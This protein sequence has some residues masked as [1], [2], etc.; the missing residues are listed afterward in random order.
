MS[1]HLFIGPMFSGKTGELLRKTT[2][3]ADTG[4]K[5]ILVIHSRDKRE[6]TYHDGTVTT[7]SSQFRNLSPKVIPMFAAT[8][9]EID[10]QLPPDV[11]VIG[12]DELQ[13]FPDI[14]TYCP[15]WASRGIE[16]IGAGL[17]GDRNRRPF[18]DVLH[19][20]PYADKCIK[21]TSAYCHQCLQEGVHRKAPFTIERG[22]S[23]DEVVVVGGESK[24]QAVCRQHYEKLRLN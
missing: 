24:Y 2:L 3:K 9:A 4:K 20:I 17:D 19:L 7:H 22:W 15:L 1:I 12:V 10:S 8:L 14:L 23:S 18:G 11:A 6:D 5:V 16:V 13:F 21:K